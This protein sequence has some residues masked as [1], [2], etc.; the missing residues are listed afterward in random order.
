MLVESPRLTT[1]DYDAWKRLEHYDDVLSQDPRFSVMASQA[2]QVITTFADQGSCYA[3]T[4][5]GKD[6]TVLAH[7]VATTETNIPLVWVRVHRWENPDC[8]LVRNIFLDQ[9]PHMQDRYHE[10]TVEASAQ[11]WWDDDTNESPSR[12]T[13]RGGFDEAARRFGSRHISGVRSEESR[14]RRIAMGRWGEAGPHACRPIGRWDATHVFAYLHRHDLPVHPAYAMS[15]GGTLDRR[16]LRV[17]SLGG[18]RG[19]DRGRA[20]WE[21]RYYPDVVGRGT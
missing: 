10:I 5:W 21:Q 9:Y 18:I 4:S 12:R 8:E 1:A 15:I 11:R 13:S 16:W 17:S 2:R 3:S 6:S 7:L 20:E 19:A 14:V